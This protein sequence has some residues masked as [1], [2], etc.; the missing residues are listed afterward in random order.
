LAKDASS[1]LAADRY[2]QALFELANE[3]GS[4]DAVATDLG[5]IVAMIAGSADLNRLVRSPVF[6]REQQ[7]AAMSEILD[8][9]GVSHLTKNFIGLV[10][11]NRRLFALTQIAKAF[12][13]LLAKHRGEISAEVTAAHTLSDA[14]VADIKG[15]LKAA[16]G[17]DPRLTLKVDS[18]LIAGLIVKVGSKMIDSSLKTKLNNLKTVLTEA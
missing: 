7:A 9:A 5:D 2:A 6:S 14:Q 11:Q 8:K 10:A 3:E 18:S 17:K 12:N 16:Y 1:N 13:V 4:L 15:S